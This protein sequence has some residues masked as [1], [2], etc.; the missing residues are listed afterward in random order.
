VSLTAVF[1]DTH[2]FLVIDLHIS[3]NPFPPKRYWSVCLPQC[4]WTFL[5]E[6]GFLPPEA[7]EQAE[8]EELVEPLE[9]VL[10][11][12]GGARG[13]WTVLGK[14]AVGSERL[15]CRLTLSVYEFGDIV[16]WLDDA[17]CFSM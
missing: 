1:D 12:Y 17:L 5:G 3:V 10:L 6:V 8:S 15:V 4:V 13:V 2:S 9:L 7:A 14:G 11:W 16:D